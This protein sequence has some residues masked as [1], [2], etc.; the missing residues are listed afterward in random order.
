MYIAILPA[1]TRWKMC[2][3][4]RNIAL[5][6]LNASSVTFPGLFIFPIAS[7]KYIKNRVFGAIFP[8]CLSKVVHRQQRMRLEAELESNPVSQEGVV[9]EES[10]KTRISDIFV[11]VRF[12]TRRV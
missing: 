7:P 10:D 2:F 4:V 11:L 3:P 1:T 12:R 8:L 9:F 6:Y 5:P